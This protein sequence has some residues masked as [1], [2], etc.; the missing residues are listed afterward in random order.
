[1]QWRKHK[2]IKDSISWLFKKIRHQRINLL[3]S[4]S[5]MHQLVPHWVGVMWSNAVGPIPVLQHRWKA[6]SNTV[7]PPQRGTSSWSS[8]CR[9]RKGLRGKEKGDNR[10]LWLNYHGRSKPDGWCGNHPRTSNPLLCL[11]LIPAEGKIE[12]LPNHCSSVFKM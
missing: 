10:G 5:Y 2:E 8:V 6:I 9:G 4:V 3:P 12:Q 11:K 1:M 7:A